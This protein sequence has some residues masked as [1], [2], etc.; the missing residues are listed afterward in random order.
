MCVLKKRYSIACV[1]VEEEVQYSMCVCVLKRY[2]IAC[3]CVE[4]EVQYSMCVC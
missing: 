4:E 1:C 2:S 3:A